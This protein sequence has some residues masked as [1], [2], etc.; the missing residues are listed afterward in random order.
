MSDS[1]PAARVGSSGLVI[2]F[3]NDPSFSMSAYS[4]PTQ[5]DASRQCRASAQVWPSK[6][7][8]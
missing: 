1:K 3:D 4:R 8:P 2:K 6:A 5:Y 7:G